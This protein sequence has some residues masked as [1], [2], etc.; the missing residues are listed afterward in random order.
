MTEKENFLINLAETLHASGLPAHRLENAIQEICEVYDQKMDVS[1]TPELLLLAIQ[2][3][4]GTFTHMRKFGGTE[5]NMQKMGALYGL[6]QECKQNELTIPVAQQ[7]L[8]EIKSM[9]NPY[10]KWIEVGSTALSTASAAC[11]F[12]GNWPEILISG[13]IG[14]AIGLL[15]LLLAYFPNLARLAV[16]FSATF[17]II[18]AQWSTLFLGNYSIEIATITGLI[19]LIP[20]FSLSLSIT[21]LANGHAQSGTV[22]FSTA[23]VTFVMIAVGIALGNQAASFLP[24]T[25]FDNNWTG[26]PEF[27]RYIALLLVPAGFMVLFIAPLRY[28][29]W[30]LVACGVSYFSIRFFSSLLEGEMAVFFAALSLAF[31]S[32]L[33]TRKFHLPVTVMLV[34]GIILLVPGSI[35]FKSVSMLV[36]A[37]TLQ[38][39]EGIFHTLLSATSLTAG[40][41]FANMLMPSRKVF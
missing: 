37:D 18:F 31:L 12:G 5:L 41:L 22:R 32:N 38:G 19:L 33:L 17:A 30:M 35:G 21:E 6:I 1:A 23:V 15:V 24:K 25:T 11:L 9:L 26:I 10:K 4:N 16:L 27:V 40:L 7:K 20:G 8:G 13:I 2:R 3:E 36:N 29:L 14:L 28:Y 39:L 34:P